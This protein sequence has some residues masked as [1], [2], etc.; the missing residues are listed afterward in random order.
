MR[1]QRGWALAAGLAEKSPTPSRDRLW[2]RKRELQR[3][4]GEVKGGPQQLY[5]P[6]FPDDSLNSR[7][8]T[9]KVLELQGPALCSLWQALARH[10]TYRSQG[11]PWGWQP[12]LR[13][14]L[15]AEEE[16]LKSELSP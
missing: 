12:C 14:L 5:P 2:D 4:L 8:L 16:G 9:P 15:G 3:G 13:Y 7:L 6:L 1:R 10:P 11:T